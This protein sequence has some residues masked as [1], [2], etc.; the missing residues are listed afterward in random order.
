MKGMIFTEYLEFI[1][2]QF[3]FD[4]ADQMIDKAGV[5]GAYTQVGQY[6]PA[7]M[8]AMVTTLAEI[9]ATPADTLQ[10]VFGRHLFHRIA[11]LYEGLAEQFSNAVELIAHVEGVIHPNVLKLYPD[12]ELPTFGTISE[13]ANELV[14]DYSSKNPFVPLCKG[15]MLGAAEFYN[16]T[17]DITYEVLGEGHD[18]AARFTI[19][20]PAA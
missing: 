19:R 12:A 20:K 17:L 7:E 10:E 4:V 11:A 5:S 14:V 16:E 9:T 2:A 13:T 8:V 18:A 6:S 15:L 3:G 1:E